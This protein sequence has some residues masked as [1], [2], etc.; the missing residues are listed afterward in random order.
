MTSTAAARATAFQALH[1]EGLLLLA[2]AWDAGSARLAQAAGA[3]AI[4]TSSAAVAWAHAWPDGD[5]L[6]VE[7]LLQTVRAVAGAVAVPVSAD[8]EGGYS[9]D[10]ARVAE[11]AGRVIDAGAVGINIEDGAADATLLCAKIAAIRAAAKTRGV[12]LFINA[13]TDVWLRGL[14]EPGRRAEEAVRRGALYREAGANGLFVPGVTTEADIAAVV[15]GAGM[16][17]NVMARPN[18]PELERLR[19]LGV[20]RFSAGS[21][22]GEAANA[23]ALAMMR[24]FLATG[25]MQTY[26][27]PLLSYP[28]LNALMG[29]E[30]RG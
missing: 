25:R 8:I 1:A 4:A 12:D 24:D 19:A 23:L 14:A 26:G 7:L 20:R 9:D 22:I 17:V 15:A 29:P 27:V 10:P 2:N 21:S 16:P 30:R 28:E 13:R 3:R 6:P 5:A 11:L 18:L